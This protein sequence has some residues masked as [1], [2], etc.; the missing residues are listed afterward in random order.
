MIPG[1][2]FGAKAKPLTLKHLRTVSYI[3]FLILVATIGAYIYGSRLDP[4]LLQNLWLNVGTEVFGI[5]LTVL[6]IEA[7][8]RRHEEQERNRVKQVAFQQLRF[9]LL[10]QLH[11]LHGM[12]KASVLHPPEKRPT[13]VR[14]LFDDRYFAEIAFLDLSKAAP[15]FTIAGP[16]QWL[17]YLN[18][19]CGNFKSSLGRTID[20]YAVFLDASTVELL[21]KMI[22]SEFL[23]Y[24]DGVTIVRNVEVKE[25]RQRTYL[26]SDSGAK[27]AREYTSCFSEFVEI[28]NAAVPADQKVT[29]HADLWRDQFG[30]A[31]AS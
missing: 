8:I 10:H 14:D 6:L 30:S 5:L 27:R 16:L 29:V 22:N 12:Y 23:W 31:R 15:A 1:K 24:V 3:L 28:Y 19:E 7:V 11:V 13:E 26:L 18:R 21:E 9:P 2:K 4:N 25:K 20:K 17:D